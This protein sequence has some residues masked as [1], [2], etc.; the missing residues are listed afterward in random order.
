MK[1]GDLVLC[2]VKEVT[3]TIT[4]VEL[5]NGKAGTIISSEIAPGRIK[6][7]RQYVVP[8]KKIVCKVL[9]ISG[10]N[11]HLSLRRVT[12][13][14]KKEIMQLF[15]QDQA[16]N[17]SFKQILGEKEELTKGKILQDFKSLTEFVE[18]TKQ[19]ESVLGRYI[20]KEKQEAIKKITNK[21][22]RS[23]ELHQ[24][25]NIK[26]LKSDG[27]MKIKKVFDFDNNAISITYISAGKFKLDLTVDDFKQGKKEM[28][29]IL[30][31]LGKRAKENDCEF[32]AIEE[33]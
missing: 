26:C 10:D 33:K 30:E 1:E 2:T 11:V 3:N 32:S 22:R 5:P 29:E 21:K 25:I 28:T 14:E 19:D 24:I 17:I 12:S 9:T 23:Q 20:P 7:M 15:Q 27:L 16:F 13:K 6:F 8:N 4:F 31:K 18:K